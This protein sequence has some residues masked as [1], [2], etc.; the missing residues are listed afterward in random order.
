MH[1]KFHSSNSLLLQYLW[2]LSYIEAATSFFPNSALSRAILASIKNSYTDTHLYDISSL[3]F[4]FVYDTVNSYFFN[5]VF[6]SPSSSAILASMYSANCLFS[7]L[8]LQCFF[9]YLLSSSSACTRYLDFIYSSIINLSYISSYS[10]LH[11]YLP[12]LPPFIPSLCNIAMI[13]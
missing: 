11:R 7:R 4:G 8:L 9:R 10:S 3:Y 6:K 5:A 1:T 12:A 2:S 13:K